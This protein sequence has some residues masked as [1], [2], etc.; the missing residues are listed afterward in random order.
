V[1]TPSGGR[2]LYFRAPA[3]LIS[4]SAGRLARNID[5]RADGGYVVAPGSQV[6]GRQ[7]QARNAVPPV[8]LPGWLTDKLTR[9]PPP[10]VPRQVRNVDMARGR[11]WAMTALRNEALAVAT[12][13]DG[14]RHDQLNRSAFSLGQLV[15]SGL[16]PA[17]AVEAS[18]AN[19][20]MQSGLPER[21]IPRIIRSG[22]TAGT[23]SP[24][25]PRQDFH[26]RTSSAG[27]PSLPR[28]P[29]YLKAPRMLL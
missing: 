20:A 4:N 12:A 22:M 19:A 21:D 10:A 17:Q 8:L 25:S 18:L 7:Y 26:L 15:G 28:D 13:V 27:R 6:G 5:V 2:H 14:T 1:S 24:R 9:K 23:R 11:A 16:L 3:T 29:P